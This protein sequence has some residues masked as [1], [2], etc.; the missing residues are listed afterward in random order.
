MPVT[1]ADVLL[2][3]LRNNPGA[4][5][6]V[7]G[8]LGAEHINIEYCYCSSGG[9]NGKVYGVFKVSNSDKAQRLVEGFTNSTKRR[10][11]RRPLRD[12]RTYT[13]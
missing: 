2:V 5:A 13:R 6:N 9:R 4:L 11:E 7:C 8:L 3:E 10:H 12:Q 1:D